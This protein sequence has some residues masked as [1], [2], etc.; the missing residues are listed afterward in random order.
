MVKNISQELGISDTETEDDRIAQLK[1]SCK[2]IM[3]YPEDY[4]KVN[5]YQCA[6]YLPNAL[7][8]F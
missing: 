1:Y 8:F 3:Q 7:K 2:I 4:E 6:Y 5:P